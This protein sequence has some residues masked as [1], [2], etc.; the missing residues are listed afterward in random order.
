MHHE[1]ETTTEPQDENKTE[2][3]EKNDKLFERQKQRVHYH[4]EANTN[5][6]PI[7]E[8]EQPVMPVQPKQPEQPEQPVNQ[9]NVSQS[10][11]GSTH[12]GDKTNVIDFPST[13]KNIDKHEEC[14]FYLRSHDECKYVIALMRRNSSVILNVESIATP[15]ERQRC[16]DMIS[17]ACYALSVQIKNI[18]NH[19]IYLLSP[20]DV[21][22]I[23]DPTYPKQMKNETKNEPLVKR[24]YNRVQGGNGANSTPFGNNPLHMSRPEP[25]RSEFSPN[26]HTARFQ[27]SVYQKHQ[28]ESISS[29]AM[30][31]SK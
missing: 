30:G 18:S 31:G 21:H 6:A 15:S 12:N 20:S 23:F 26:S 14:V 10:H 3:N 4:G 19:G 27:G 2:R 16:I 7:D 22:V 11:Q 9:A 17:G 29:I 8:P 24:R 1:E 25:S 5:T 28:G 13:P